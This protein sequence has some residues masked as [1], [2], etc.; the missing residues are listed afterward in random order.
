MVSSKC[1]RIWRCASP[2]SQKRR[3]SRR[4]CSSL[5]EQLKD[6]GGE[7][8]ESGRKPRANCP[9]LVKMLADK[10]CSYVLYGTSLKPKR[11]RRGSLV[12]IFWAPL[13]SIMFYAAPRMPSGWG[14][15]YK[16]TATRRP[17]TTAHWQ[18]NQEAMLSSRG[19]SPCEPPLSPCLELLADLLLGI[20]AVP[21]LPDWRWWRI[22]M[23]EDQLN[24]L[25]HPLT[26]PSVHHPWQTA[27][28]LLI[29][30]G[31][32]TISFPGTQF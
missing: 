28:D 2:Q 21:F 6:P 15:N 20:Q 13:K 16:Q 22:S 5:W 10:G 26:K 29:P 32:R 7:Q 30:L 17:R 11:T 27:T 9:T 12:F 18:K 23:G 24:T 19:E 31:I 4:P 3:H 14:M 25:P 8:G 1:S